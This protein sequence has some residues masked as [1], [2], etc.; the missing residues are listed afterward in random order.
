MQGGI[1]RRTFVAAV[2]LLAAVG[3]AGAEFP[4]RPLRILGGFAAGGTSD[5]VARIVAEAVSPLL[6]QRVV[7]ENRTGASGMIAAEAMVRGAP[8]DGYTVYQ[9]ASLITVLPELPGMRLPIDPTTELLP[10][11]NVAH[12]SQAMAVKADAPWRTVAD[13]VAAARARPGALTYASSG[14]GALSHLSG[15]RLEQLAGIRMV[16]VPYRGAAL[17]VVDVIGGRAD[18]II[19]NLG[20]VVAQVRGGEMRLLGF[21]DGMGSPLFPEVPQIGATVPGYAISGWFGICGPRGM[22]AEAVE[23]WQRAIGA[24]LQ[25]AAWRRRL[26]E[27]GLIP[28]FEDPAAF[29]R[30]MQADRAVWRET[31]RAAN[32]RVE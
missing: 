17:G 27:N 2:L 12:S 22:P 24:A 31:I 13:F 4:D 5:L 21:A 30:T 1:V 23:R 7:V 3:P 32:I 6:G 10:I 15:A 29:A 28:R 8:Q 14:I 19:T 20:D 16:H 9:C 11:A 26:E 18:T 25:D